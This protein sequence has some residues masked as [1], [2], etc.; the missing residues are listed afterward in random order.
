[1]CGRDGTL[2]VLDAG[3][4]I[5][6]LGA[7]LKAHAPRRIHVLLSHLHM[8]HIQG[9]GFFEE[10]FNPEVETHLSA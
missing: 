6:L 10:L 5:R 9:L 8:D 3:T 4:G 1:V 7:A 2:L